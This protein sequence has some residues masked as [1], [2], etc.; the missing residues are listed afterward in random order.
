MLVFTPCI[1]FSDG[2]MGYGGP[3]L[4]INSVPVVFP[5][6]MVPFPLPVGAATSALQLVGNASLASIDAK[7]TNPLPVSGNL[8]R[9]WVLDSST[10]S[11][12]ISNFPGSLIVTQG[13]TPWIVDGSAYTQP[14][15]AVSLPLPT[16]AS[17]SALQVAGNLS[18]ASIDS[19]LTSPLTVTVNNFPATQPVSGTVTAL[20][21]TTPWVTDGSGFT[22]PISA[23]SL[24][25]PTGAATSA[26]QTAGN[27][28][29]ASIDAKLTNPLPVSGSLGRTWT[30]SSATDSVSVSAITGSVTVSQGTTPWIVDGSAYTQPVSAL[31]L[32]LPTGAA[33]SALQ[34]AGNASLVSIDSKLTSPLTITGTVAAT[35]S[36]AW[37]TG[38][39]WTLSSG[40]DSISAAI[41][42]FPATVAVTQSTS[43]W[44]VS[45]TVTANAGTNLNT[46]LL[47]LDTSVNG[48]LLGQNSV[49]AAQTGPLVQGA[50]TAAAPSYT[51]A[52]TSPL[53]LTTA[54]GLRVD[55]SGST[56]PISG[57]VT[58]NQGTSPWV[59]SASQSG[60][61]TVQ[62]GNTANTTPWL[63]T[64]NQGGNSAT[65][66]ASN[67]LKVDG[68][69][70]TQPVSGTVA[71]T[72]S[73][74]WTVTANAGTNLNTSLLALESGGNLASIKTNTD[75]LNL[76]QAS[77]TSGQKG[78][79]V[80]GAATTA[81]PSYTTGQS[82]PFSLTTAGALRTDS[83]ATTQ[84]ISGTVTASED[85]NY[86]TVGATTLR[87]AAQIGNATGAAAFGSGT[88]TAQTL[89]VVLPTDQPALTTAATAATSSH[90]LVSVTTTASTILAANSSRKGFMVTNVGGN[91]VYLGFGFTP[92]TSDYSVSIA[93]TTGND[94]YE[95]LTT[96]YTGAITAIRGS[97]S[98]NVTVVEFT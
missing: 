76:A 28:S 29:L 50:V 5:T 36:G 84:P 4:S 35:Q 16:G 2:N 24:P 3:Q 53:S 18:L 45:G 87:T 13:T 26:L 72:Q 71:A 61:W 30:L 77:T 59:T 78:N 20:Q 89:R 39:T 25:L 83:S 46:S 91:T 21:G 62:P 42:N 82:N 43:P 1:Q 81:S 88:T 52:R 32:P 19:K 23:S 67:A 98:T 85:K 38:R 6:D 34:T 86:G 51:T 96:C 14:I 7:L 33:T 27:L 65:V 73:G 94:R 48:I 17:T 63:M 56:Q 9:T 41:S 54:G 70:V 47:A 92:T 68:S 22:Q 93:I 69:A 37:S 80:L 90:T 10:D 74:T 60:T 95:P 66:T 64:I 55:G 31:S 44:V 97:G 58:A 15:S 75:N 12:S 11:V 40:T 79:L 57:T 49:T 8:G